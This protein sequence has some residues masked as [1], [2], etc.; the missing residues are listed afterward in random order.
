VKLVHLRQEDSGG[1]RRAAPDDAYGENDLETSPLEADRDLGGDAL[2]IPYPVQ[3]RTTR[4]AEDCFSD[5]SRG[6]VAM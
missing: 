4:R 1:N 6:T 5:A 2:D 3:K